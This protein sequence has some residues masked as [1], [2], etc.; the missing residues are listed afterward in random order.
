[1]SR[2]NGTSVIYLSARWFWGR[3]GIGFVLVK[4]EISQELKVFAGQAMGFSQNYDMTEIAEFGARVADIPLCK[5]MFPFYKDEK[6]S[7]E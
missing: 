1:M 6:W 7:R 5:A 2:A 3:N 4:D